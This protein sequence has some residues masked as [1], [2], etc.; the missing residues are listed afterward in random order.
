LSLSVIR[1][2]PVRASSQ[3]RV[4]SALFVR[5]RMKIHRLILISCCAAIVALGLIFLLAVLDDAYSPHLPPAFF[6][7]VVL[8]FDWPFCTISALL[9]GDPPPGICWWIL[10]G[11]TGL[12]WGAVVEFIFT[13]KKKR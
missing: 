6:R 9:H 10:I 11:V 7:F 5:P 8:V 13:L 1:E 12:F 4:G 3:V 2:R